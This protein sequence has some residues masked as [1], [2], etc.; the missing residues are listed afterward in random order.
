MA[1]RPSLPRV[2]LPLPKRVVVRLLDGWPGR[3][4]TVRVPFPKRLVMAVDPSLLRVMVPA[5]KGR[6]CAGRSC[7]AVKTRAAMMSRSFITV[8]R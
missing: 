5:P 6:G 7:A 4:I 8:R 2:K 3:V 1:V